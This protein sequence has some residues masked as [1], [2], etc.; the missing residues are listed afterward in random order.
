MLIHYEDEGKYFIR[1]TVK[2]IMEYLTK[3]ET[4]LTYNNVGS[5][6]FELSVFKDDDDNFLEENDEAIISYQKDVLGLKNITV[7]KVEEVEA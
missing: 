1:G 6:I 7:K 4:H 2:E 3:K 5:L